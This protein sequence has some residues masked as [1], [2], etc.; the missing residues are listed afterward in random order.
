M[1]PKIES[2]LYPQ[3]KMDLMRLAMTRARVSGVPTNREDRRRL[4][5]ELRKLGAPE[6][7]VTAPR[8]PEKYR[9]TPEQDEPI[10]LDL[11]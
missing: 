4:N 2:L 7:Q 8:T 9:H 1:K 10:V 6:L 5:A 11:D 3:A